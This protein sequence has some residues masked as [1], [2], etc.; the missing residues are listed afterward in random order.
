MGEMIRGHWVWDKEQH[1]FVE[2][3]KKKKDVN[4]PAIIGDEIEP[5]MSMTGSDKIY[6][7]KSALR[8]EYK[9]MGYVEVGEVIR[10]TPPKIDKEKRRRE[11]REDLE[12]TLND[13]RYG[14]IPV[15]E[16]ERAKCKEEERQYQAYLKR[17]H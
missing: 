6:T 3:G 2:F 17:Q 10:H 4:A 13:L 12:K 5:T 7:S 1:K 11:I 8:R 9:E 16:K 14:N 15:S